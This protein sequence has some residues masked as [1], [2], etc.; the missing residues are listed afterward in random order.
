MTT[1]VLRISRIPNAA[2]ATRKSLPFAEERDGCIAIR[3]QLGAGASLNE[4]LVWLWGAVKL[5]R[6]FL[7]SLQSEGAVITV[8]ATCRLPVVIQP[9]GAELLHLLN[10]TLKISGNDA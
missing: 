2:A 10:A 9:N 1:A 6:R 3:S 7:K 8:E 4:H 5:E